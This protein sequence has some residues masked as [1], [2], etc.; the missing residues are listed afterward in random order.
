MPARELGTE[1][2]RLRK[3]EGLSIEEAADR[4]GLDV[5]EVERAETVGLG[6]LFRLRKRLFKRV[7]GYT[8][9]GPYY[10]LRPLDD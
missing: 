3:R 6:L 8:L 10:R 9:E 4:V 7:G 5:S 1:L 2:R